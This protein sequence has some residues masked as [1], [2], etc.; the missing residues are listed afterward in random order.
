VNG[1]R[2]DDNDF[3]RFKLPR[4]TVTPRDTE[5]GASL[6]RERYLSLTSLAFYASCGRSPYLA[7]LSNRSRSWSILQSSRNERAQGP[8]RPLARH[9]LTNNKNETTKGEKTR[10]EDERKR[11]QK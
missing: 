9:G 8:R 11:S 5:R 6:E 10:L 7:L 4:H 3:G 2:G 1:S